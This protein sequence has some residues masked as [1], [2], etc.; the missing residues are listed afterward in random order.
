MSPLRVFW[1]PP[2]YCRLGAGSI[3]FRAIV[4][5]KQCEMRGLFMLLV[6]H[7]WIGDV[8]YSQ[9]VSASE[10]TCIVSGGALNSTRSLASVVLTTAWVVNC[11]GKYDRGQRQLHHAELHWLE[12]MWQV[13]SRSSFVWRCVS[14]F[15]VVP[16]T[17]CPSC[18][19]RLPKSLNDSTFCSVSCRLLIVSRIQLNTY[20]RRAFTVIGPTVWNALSNDHPELSIASFGRLLKTRSCQQYLVHWV[21]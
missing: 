9:D 8:Q 10:I 2:H 17:T 7:Y 21:H 6:I 1:L 20:G 18:V 13:G 16:W 15:T 5:N 19:R 14:V 3:P 11:T 12:S 4:N